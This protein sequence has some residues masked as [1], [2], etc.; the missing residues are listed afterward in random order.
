MPAGVGCNHMKFKPKTKR[1]AFTL[2]EL[3]VVIAIIAIL[4]GMLLPSLAKAKDRAKRIQCLNNTR[5]MAIAAHMYSEENKAGAFADT[6]GPGD[7]DLTWL[8]PEKIRSLKSYTCP[9][10]QNF[11]RP[12]LQTRHPIKRSPVLKDLLQTALTPKDQPGTSYEV[13]G[14]MSLNP[15]VQKTQ[16]SAQTYQHKQNTF[17]LRGM[18]PGPSQLWL[19]VDADDGFQ[20]TRNNYPDPVDNHGIDGSNVAFCDSHAEFVKQAEYVYR[21]EISQDEGRQR[22]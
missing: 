3:L 2:I 21:Y 7:D 16:K 19:I 4:A 17:G 22:P 6:S 12:E 5:Q 18:I 9:G 1:K 13:Y 14:Y 8:H 10:T 15:R 20:G 11:I